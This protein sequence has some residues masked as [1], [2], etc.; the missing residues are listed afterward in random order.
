MG[1]GAGMGL[2]NI[3]KYSDHLI[4]TSEVGTGTCVTMTVMNF[5]RIL[6]PDLPVVTL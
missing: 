5:N 3:K 1:F 4:I 6:H 2:A